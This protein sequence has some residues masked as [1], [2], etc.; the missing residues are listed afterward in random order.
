[1]TQIHH[2]GLTVSNLERA[3]AF[4][5]DALGMQVVMQQDRQGGYFEA[6]NV[7][8]S[9]AR[10]VPEPS[11]LPGL[12]TSSRRETADRRCFGARWA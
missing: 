11:D 3:L 4:W 12:S 2:T 10:L 9:C 1:M 7:S 5:S 8:T 6:I